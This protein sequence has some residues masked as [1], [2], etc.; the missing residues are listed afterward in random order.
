MIQ[1]KLKHFIVNFL[2]ISFAIFLCFLLT[3]FIFIKISHQKL[4]PRSLAGSLPNILF[5]FYGD[6]YSK[7]SLKKYTAILGGSYAQEL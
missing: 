2:S 5:T 1:I 3:N 4:F 6:T 7:K